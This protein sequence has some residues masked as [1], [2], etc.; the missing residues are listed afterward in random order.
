M[1]DEEADY[2][3]YLLRL[4]RSKRNNRVVWQ[5][6]LESTRT[7]E[8]NHFANLAELLTYLNDHFTETD[9]NRFSDQQLPDQ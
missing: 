7:G 4:R 2:A 8:I 9:I 3:S 1:V 5:V 6:S